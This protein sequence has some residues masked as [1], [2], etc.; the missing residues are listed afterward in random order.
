MVQK[1]KIYNVAKLFPTVLVGAKKW[2]DD[3]PF[4][5]ILKKWGVDDAKFLKPQIFLR[6]K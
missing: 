4:L 2:G 5:G 6:V 3:W 1:Y